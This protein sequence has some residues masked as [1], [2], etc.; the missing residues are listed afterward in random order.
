MFVSRQEETESFSVFCAR[1]RK[2]SGNDLQ[3][4]NRIRSGVGHPAFAMSEE[5]SRRSRLT[6]RTN[7]T[8][9][10]SIGC[11]FQTCFSKTGVSQNVPVKIDVRSDQSCAI[12]E[13]GPHSCEEDSA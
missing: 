2:R 12:D 4:A 1:I 5:N 11:I 7:S 6:K 3:S 9:V 8:V 10:R 13:A